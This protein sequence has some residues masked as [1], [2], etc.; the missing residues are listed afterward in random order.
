MPNADQLFSPSSAPPATG[1][2]DELFGGGNAQE[3]APSALG[4]SRAVLPQAAAKDALASA[5][6]S[7]P[8]PPTPEDIRRNRVDISTIVRGQAPDAKDKRFGANVDTTE[9]GAERMVSG[10]A[11]GELPGVGTAVRAAAKA[12]GYKGVGA[13]AEKAANALGNTVNSATINAITNKAAGVSSLLGITSKL[14]DPIQKI[15]DSLYTLSKAASGMKMQ[16]LVDVKN[17]LPKD[18]AEHS[19]QIYHSFEDPSISLSP[20]AQYIKDKMISPIMAKNQKMKDML[21]VLGVKTGPEVENYVGRV[22]VGESSLVD[23]LKN[24]LPQAAPRGISTFAPEMQARK[25]FGMEGAGEQNLHLVQAKNNSSFQVWRGGKIIGS[26]KLGVDDLANKQV[27]FM[28]ETFKLT[29]STTKAI[30]ANTPLRYYHDSLLSA[31][32]GNINLN[33]ALHNAQFLEQFKHSPEFKQLVVGPTKDAPEG[34]REVNI[35][36]LK[37]YKFSERVANVLDDYSGVGKGGVLEQLGRINRVTVGALFWNPLPH[38]MNVLDHKMIEGGLVG[39]IKALTVGLPDTIKTALQ[40]HSE[41]MNMGPLYRQAIKEGAGLVYPSVVTK[42]FAESMAKELGTAPEMDTVAKAWGYKNPAQMVQRIYAHSSKSLWSWNDVIMMHGY[43]AK[44]KAGEELGA[45]IRE[46]EKHIPN[47]RIPDQVLGS[48][49]VSQ[50]LR[51][52]AVTA[53]GRYDYG[54]LASYGNMVKDLISRDSSIA[55]RAHALDQMAMLATASLVVYPA[56]D[57]LIQKVT[58]NDHATLRRFGANGPVDAIYKFT[59]GQTNFPMLMG[60]MLPISPALKLPVELTSGLDTFSGQRIGTKG[61]P[62]SKFVGQQVAPIGMA[63]QV[64]SGR[65]SGPEMLAAQLGINLPSAKETASR[66]KAQKRDK[67]PVIW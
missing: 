66:E 9:A 44:M 1:N 49:A 10:F 23:T 14:G 26:G 64:A 34:F 38:I 62:V 27:K 58:G 60:T 56:F 63:E 33:E 57:S 35:P 30:E 29:D 51:H 11:M 40:A 59:T 20:R 37:G 15:S 2:A 32:Q 50:V 36:Q 16:W 24:V 25:V 6:A 28:G 19:E 55:D 67:K 7:A 65:K 21:T 46:T 42:N 61:E 43:I 45:A 41:V 12:L 39:N 54:R 52:P 13:A 47:Y 53:F 5:T 3:Q 4:Q 48:R 8:T 18:Y 31:I 17:F 22:P